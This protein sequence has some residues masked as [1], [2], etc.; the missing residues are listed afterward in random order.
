MPLDCWN[1]DCAD[2]KVKFRLSYLKNKNILEDKYTRSK[3]EENKFNKRKLFESFHFHFVSVLT[4]VI[5]I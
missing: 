1:L 5:H 2:E 4:K 3:L